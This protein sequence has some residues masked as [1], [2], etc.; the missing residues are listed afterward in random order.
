MIFKV[1]DGE[2]LFTD[3]KMRD[4]INETVKCLLDTIEEELYES[5]YYRVS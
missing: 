4:T 1:A 3:F 2:V 5:K